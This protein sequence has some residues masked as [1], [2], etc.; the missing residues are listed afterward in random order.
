MRSI[1]ISICL[2]ILFSCCNDG[3]RGKVDIGGATLSNKMIR[4]DRI[5]EI[6]IKETKDKFISDIRNKRARIW[7]G[8]LII[9]DKVQPKLF[10]I[11]I[12]TGEIVRVLGERGTGPGE[13]YIIDAFEID[14]ETGRLYIYDQVSRRISCIDSSGRFLYSFGFPPNLIPSI[15][16]IKLRDGK[17]YVGVVESKYANLS[18]KW[19]SRIIGVLDL[20]GNLLDLF[21]V[22]DEISKTFTYGAGLI[23]FDYD[24]FGNW[25]SVDWKTYRIYKYDKSYKLIKTF[26]VQG[27]FRLPREDIP[28]NLPFT[29]IS[30][31]LTRSSATGS[32]IVFGDYIYYQFYDL[33]DRTVKT[34]RALDSESII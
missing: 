6:K 12:K 20:R 11:D 27:K 29:E 19:K 8:M 21:G 22:H 3:S 30:R 1:F 7:K 15:Q 14:Q 2:F 23:E 24:R 28:W 10:F 13:F 17:L 25:Y 16:D 32:I 5:G 34:R 9:I 26:G 33:T 31:R 18:E 4:I